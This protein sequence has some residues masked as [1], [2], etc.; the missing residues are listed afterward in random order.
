[1]A[2][3]TALLIIDVQMA[4]FNPQEPVYQH[5]ALI[6]KLRDLIGRA[7]AADIPVIYVQHQGQG[8]DPL[9]PGRPE[10]EIHSAIAPQEGEPVIHKMHP[11]SFQ[12]TELQKVLEARGIKNLVM[13]GLQTEYCMDTSCRRAYSLGYKVTLV[14]DCH[15]TWDN[16]IITAEQIIAHHN[17]TLGGWFARLKTAAEVTF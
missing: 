7:R 3:D 13:A 2:N 14:K 4:M 1:M 11:D 8:E 17:Q 15:S 16:G 9:Q 12:E 5:E 10:W 6:E